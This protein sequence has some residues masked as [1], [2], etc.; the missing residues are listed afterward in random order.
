MPVGHWHKSV[1]QNRHARERK[2]WGASW[3]TQGKVRGGV[4]SG[5]RSGLSHFLP[6]FQAREGSGRGLDLLFSFLG[7]SGVSRGYTV[8]FSDLEE[9]GRLDTG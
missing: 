9:T 6:L 8:Q 5:R 1:T 4:V 7:L 3:G 2:N